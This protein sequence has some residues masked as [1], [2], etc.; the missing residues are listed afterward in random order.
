MSDDAQRKAERKAEAR[1]V[2]VRERFKM[3]GMALLLMMDQL[4]G[5]MRVM[6]EE[7]GSDAPAFRALLMV[8]QQALVQRRQL[9]ALDPATPDDVRQR[10]SGSLL[11]AP[12]TAE[13]T[14]RLLRRMFTSEG[15]AGYSAA[16]GAGVI[17]PFCPASA[18]ASYIHFRETSGPSS[19]EVAGHTT[20]IEFES[21][22]CPHRWAL[23]FGFHKG[24][25][26][27]DVARLPDAEEPEQ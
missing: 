4:D 13:E 21:E 24:A 14:T 8:K 18:Q 17:C 20:I 19:L 15:V 3:A 11:S 26:F 12:V 6:E 2:E 16:E 10:L 23:A 9:Y 27:V 1:R 5:L 7:E 22:T 25:T